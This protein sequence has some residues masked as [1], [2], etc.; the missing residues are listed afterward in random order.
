MRTSGFPKPLRR[1]PPRGGIAT[2]FRYTPQMGGLH[3]PHVIIL[4]GF[5]IYHVQ[6]TFAARWTA[7]ILIFHRLYFHSFI[8]FFATVKINSIIYNGVL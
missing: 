7:D 5:N 3:N 2:V 4:S 6:S 8:T 1:G